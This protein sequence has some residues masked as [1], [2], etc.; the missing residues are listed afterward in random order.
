MPATHER[1]TPNVKSK[2]CSVSLVIKETPRMNT[3]SLP[4][5][6]S[7]K[8]K[9]SPTP[10]VG[11]GSG[12]SCAPGEADSGP[13]PRLSVKAGLSPL[14]RDLPAVQFTYSLFL[15]CGQ[16][17]RS[18]LCPGTPH[19]QQP[20]PWSH[21]CITSTQDSTW[22]TVG[23]GQMYRAILR[24]HSPDLA[25]SFLG[26]Y[27][28]EIRPSAQRG[29]YKKG[30]CYIAILTERKHPNVLQQE[31]KKREH[32]IHTEKA[33][34]QGPMLCSLAHPSEPSPRRWGRGPGPPVLK[35]VQQ[36][37]YAARTEDR[38]LSSA[39]RRCC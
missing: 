20:G 15:A 33:A 9:T 26:I 13:L 30:H 37:Q 36:V 31:I 6:L 32:C 16:P 2:R 28:R 35:S 1:N 14:P 5:R 29:M 17:A 34:K 21:R 3:I 8:M 10:R 19:L 7:K 11:E 23:A 39:D 22:L 38:C 27:P 12:T 4:F 18:P 25:M 24:R